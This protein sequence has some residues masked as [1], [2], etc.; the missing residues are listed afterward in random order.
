MITLTCFFLNLCIIEFECT[1]F[2]KKHQF[3][4]VIYIFFDV[5]QNCFFSPPKF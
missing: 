2:H 3:H 1:V 4:L 5:L